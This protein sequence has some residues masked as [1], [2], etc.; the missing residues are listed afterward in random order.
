MSTRDEEKAAAARASLKYIEPG[1][2]VGLGSGST[3]TLAIQFIGEAVSQGLKIRGIP[4]S[5]VSGALARSLGIPLI[6]LEE[7]DEIDVTIDGA[8]EIAPGLQLIK[9][10][11]GYLLHEKIVA[12]STKRLVIVADE[13]KKVAVLGAFPLPVEV[14]LFAAAPVQRRLQE[15]GAHPVLRSGPEGKPFL[16]DEGNVIFDCSFGRIPNPTA[17]AQALKSIPGIVEHGLFLDMAS[18]AIVAGS[19]GIEV[20][21]A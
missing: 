21:T 14:V 10:G 5:K 15:M 6:T 9:G 18:V 2:V 3:A 8:D 7:A 12:A 20:L 4:T 13:K 17:T 1:M 11:G 16:T 19:S